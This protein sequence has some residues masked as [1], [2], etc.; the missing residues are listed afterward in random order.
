MSAMPTYDWWDEA[1]R[2]LTPGELQ[3]LERL[4]AA[5]RKAAAPPAKPRQPG[6]RI[7][8]IPDDPRDPPADFRDKSR[9]GDAQPVWVDG[10]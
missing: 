1:T 5:R 10:I 3:E 4:L 7:W 8:F 9:P 6:N 2:Q